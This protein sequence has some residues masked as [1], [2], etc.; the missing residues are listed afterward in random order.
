M[1]HDP[2]DMRGQAAQRDK[3]EHEKRLIS[4]QEAVDIQWLM[5][6]PRGR[7]L[8][9]GWLAFCGMERTSFTGDSKTFFREGM[10]NVGLMLTA[11]MTTHAME[12]YFQMLRE[13]LAGTQ[14][15]GSAHSEKADR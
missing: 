7:R 9:R 12:G 15:Q 2:L 5:A 10:R 4:E 14:P 13:H 6:D 1:K 11:Q 8:M 3:T